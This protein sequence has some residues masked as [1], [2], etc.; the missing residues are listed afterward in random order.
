MNE[1]FDESPFDADAVQAGAWDDGPYGRGDA[2]G[3][4]NEVTD[5]TRRAALALLDPSKPVV[6]VSLG[7]PIHTGYP[8]YGTR[9]Y[10]QHLVVEGVDPGPGFEGE[11]HRDRPRGRNLSVSLEERVTTSYNI[12]TKVNGLLHVAV[13]EVAYGGRRVRDLVSTEGLRDLDVTTWG[14]PLLTR[15]VLVD[16]LALKVEAGDESALGTASD[17]RPVLRGDLRITLE[18]LLGAIERQGVEPP[19]PGDAVVIRTGWSRVID[20]RDRYLAGSPGVFL[21]ECRWLASRRPA[22]V[23]VDAWCWGAIS[24]QVESRLVSVC[25]QELLVH[26]GIRLGES[27]NLEDLAATGASEF[28]LTHTP[29]P[30]RGAV[31]SSTPPL[32]ILNRATPEHS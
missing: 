24:A 26:H 19:G 28:V 18:D 31:S 6:T 5:E 30:A 13:G 2:L 29:L 11:V 22:L 10:A 9:G 32:A 25:H 23:G 12:G 17:G 7:Q 14:P 20:E 27:L 4:Y 3:T 1:G 21:R 15:G 16:V 8:G